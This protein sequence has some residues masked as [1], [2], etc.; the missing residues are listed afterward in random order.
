MFSSTAD[1]APA[2]R[3]PWLPPSMSGWPLLSEEASTGS[4]ATAS[5][6]QCDAK[7][8]VQPPFPAPSG[9]PESFADERL[10]LQNQSRKEHMYHIKSDT[11]PVPGKTIH[12]VPPAGTRAPAH[13]RIQ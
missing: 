1:N 7:H 9:S 13:P 3:L 5:K 8:N 4:A 11:K 12:S 2:H 6:T 10:L